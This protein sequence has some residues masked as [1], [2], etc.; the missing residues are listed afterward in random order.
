MFSKDTYIRRRAEL[1]KIV[2]EGVIVL[3]GNND[4]PCN[5]PANCY[6]PMR[7]DSSFLY[8]FGQH[9]NGLV[10]V[11]DI[12]NDEE[13]LFGDDIDVEDIVWMGF[14][15]SVADLAAEVGVTKTAP[16]KSLTAHLSARPLVACTARPL[17]SKNI[18]FLPP[19]RHDTQIQIMDLLG[20][21]PSKQKEAASL[22]LIQAVVK[23]RS[24]KEAQEIEAIDRACDVGYAMHTTAQLLIKPGVTERFIGGQVDGIARSLADQTSFATI[25]S[26]HGEIMHGNPTANKLEDGRLVLCDAG[27]ELDDYCS[28]HTRTMP[29]N[30]KFTQRQ[31]EIY[32]IVE[33]CHDYVL[34]VAK[35]GVKYM[36]VH[37]AVC[38]MMTERLKELG[39]MKGDTDEAV[40]AGA[41]AM[42]LPHGLG[43]MMGMDVHDMEGLGQ[44]FVGFDEE[45]RPNLEQF[46]TNCLRMGRRLQEGFVVTDEPGIYFIPALI[47]EW[48]ASGHCKEFIN[49]EKLET[50]KDFGGIRIE[51][52]VLITSDG[53]RFLGAKRIPYHP[54]ELEAFMS[55]NQ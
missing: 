19:Y 31:L 6:A 43:H 16:M 12:D 17:T 49:Y 41:H 34:E 13:W 21:H 28:D 7:Q 32:S 8:Y 38:R 44:I 18:H 47:D 30:G 51:D 11:I 42:F 50:Y 27:C 48:K 45:T 36:D 23:M 24:T 53:C 33:A 4:A 14:T 22:E 39:L 46:G 15:P 29:V 54:A 9:R 5:Y 1:K 10:G 20:I 2:G 55:K 40:K 3:F 52:D 37:F 26:Q 35:P 25:F